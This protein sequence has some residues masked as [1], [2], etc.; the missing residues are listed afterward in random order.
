MSKAEGLN[1]VCIIPGI[2]WPLIDC[3][4]QH[5]TITNGYADPVASTEARGGSSTWL[6][7]IPF[8]TIAA[9][10]PFLPRKWSV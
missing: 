4:K 5:F 6:W 10:P 3:C 9:V 8:L 1:D 7:G 2:A